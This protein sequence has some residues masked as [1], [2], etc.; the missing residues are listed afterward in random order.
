MD[1]SSK[2]FETHVGPVRDALIAFLDEGEALR[3]R[4]GLLPDA[5]SRAMAEIASEGHYAGA[6]PWGDDPVQQAHHL[7]Q[8]LLLSSD[9]S[10]RAAC[11]LLSEGEAPVFA[12]IVLARSSLEHAGRAWW[13]LDPGLTIRQRI[14]R[15]FN[16]RLNSLSE[17]IM[18]A[19]E[20]DARRKARDRIRG[21]LD[22][23]QRIGFRKLPAER[24]RPTSLDEKRPSSTQL[25]GRLLEIGGDETLGKLVYSYF[26]AVTHGTAFG[27]TQ[28]VDR[29]TAIAP[30]E[31][32]LPQTALFTSSQ[33]VCTVLTGLILGSGRALK[34]RNDL[35]AW[36]S[37]EWSSSM[38]AALRAARASLGF[39]A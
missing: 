17:Q 34:A 5:D 6:S 14:V 35:F 19:P 1:H 27:L 30:P 31:L 20:R 36:E 33:A 13:L 22:E 10:T 38:V 3:Q 26:S 12:H 11:Q 37:T 32:G 18:L 28:S 2:A 29:D 9:D 4:W 15:G 23:G 24:G 39:A 21:I 7:G 16:E 25:M 8:L